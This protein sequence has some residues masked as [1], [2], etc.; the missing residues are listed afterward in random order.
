M[1]WRPVVYLL[2]AFSALLMATGAVTGEDGITYFEDFFT[3]DDSPV[4]EDKWKVAKLQDASSTGVVNETM[5]MYVKGEDRV[6]ATP[7]V[8][9]NDYPVN[10]EFMW[11]QEDDGGNTLEVEVQTSDDTSSWKSVEWFYYH[12]GSLGWSHGDPTDPEAYNWHSRNANAELWTWYKVEMSIEDRRITF[13]AS[14]P[15]SGVTLY[16]DYWCLRG[17]ERVHCGKHRRF[18]D[19]RRR[20]IQRDPYRG[21]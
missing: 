9:V 19:P 16:D 1:I 8:V 13:K 17:H 7:L 4:D 15:G 18:P 2:F 3:Q 5:R 21:G 14:E 6:V 10:V 12:G 11:I 20:S